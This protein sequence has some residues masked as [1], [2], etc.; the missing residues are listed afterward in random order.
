MKNYIAVIEVL[1]NKVSRM[2]EF[3]TQEEA[4]ALVAE[5][6]KGYVAPKPAD[7]DIEYWVADKVAQTLTYDSASHVSADARV[8]I[9]KEIARL[10]RLETPR[11]LAESVLSDEGKAWLTVNREMIATERNKL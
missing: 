2:N 6:G 4:G 3:D 11:R 9:L 10:E 8:V 1:N 5:K 7:C